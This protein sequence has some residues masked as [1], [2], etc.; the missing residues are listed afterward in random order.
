MLCEVKRVLELFPKLA[1]L[2]FKRYIH[3]FSN[4]L[5]DSFQQSS[6]FFP[7][8]LD[9]KSHLSIKYLY[10]ITS[11]LIQIFYFNDPLSNKAEES[12]YF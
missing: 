9:I 7:A 4:L 1:A 11:H 10:Q 3:I 6:N 8:F 5:A 2:S 12:R